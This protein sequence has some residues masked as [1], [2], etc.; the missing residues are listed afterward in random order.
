MLPYFKTLY[1]QNPK[2]IQDSLVRIVC[3]RSREILVNDV[4]VLAGY[5]PHFPI[6]LSQT[7]AGDSFKFLC[8]MFSL[9]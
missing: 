8:I 3:D 6:I 9:A 7:R 5:Y 4:R 2:N 1:K